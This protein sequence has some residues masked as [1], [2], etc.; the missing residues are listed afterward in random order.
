MSA[1]LRATKRSANHTEA[2]H[3]LRAIYADPTE[4]FDTRLQAALV[5]VEVN[6][7]MDPNEKA[8]QQLAQQLEARSDE[9]VL[10][11]VDLNVSTDR[12]DDP[13]SG[14]VG[15][16]GPLASYNYIDGI[17]GH[18]KF[19]MPTDVARM[20]DGWHKLTGKWPAWLYEE[21]NEAASRK[22]SGG[23]VEVKITSWDESLRGNEFIMEPVEFEAPSWSDRQ[24]RHSSYYD[25]AKGQR[26]AVIKEGMWA[27]RTY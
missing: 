5:L 2:L 7:P 13:Y 15:G 11:D 8:A 14:F 21:A 6:A 23:P 20:L 4:S 27:T 22:L 12:W 1:T 10:T 24:R 18:V 19:E 9:I 17:T 3:Q 26:H 16:V 25:E